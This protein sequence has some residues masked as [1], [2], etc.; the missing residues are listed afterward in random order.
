M[1]EAAQRRIQDPRAEFFV[2][3]VASQDADYSFVSG[4][5]NMK[6][7]AKEDEWRDFVYENLR[8][9][10]SHTRVALGFNMLSMANPHREETLYYADPEHMLAF[11]RSEL[12]PNVRTVDRLEPREFVAFLLR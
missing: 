2:S 7:W 9:L 10:W 8:D 3:H 5:W 11:C 12:T 1:I 6:M 4:T